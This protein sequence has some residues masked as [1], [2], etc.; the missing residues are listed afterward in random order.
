MILP[1]YRVAPSRIP[2]AGQ[3]LFL[4][5]PVSRAAVIIAPDN[6]H[7]LWPEEKLRACP[8]DSIEVS[9]SVRWFERW[10]S[11]TPEWSDECFVNHSFE[12]SGLWHLGFIF[13][14]ADLVA[15]TEITADYR[16]LLGS[17]E[18]AGFA[19]G[20]TGRPIVGLPWRDN[21][22]QSAQALLRLLE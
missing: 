18:D 19:C 4:D 14:A 9:S 7:T 8:A 11:L 1:R 3:G 17:G 10:F 21:L 12:P 2:G 22:Q 15:G 5:E 13:A 20:H 16:F 6:V